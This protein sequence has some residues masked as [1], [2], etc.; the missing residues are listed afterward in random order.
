MAFLGGYFGGNDAGRQ[1]IDQAGQALMAATGAANKKY[2]LGEKNA[3]GQ[4]GTNYYDPYTQSGNQANDMYAN[5]LGLR[6]PGGNQA[7]V[8]AYQTN[9]GYGFQMQQG[10]QALDRS[11]AGSGMFGSGNAAMALNQF[12]QGVANQ[13][14]GNWLSRLQGLGAQG[15]Q[16]A[17]GQ[18]GRQGSLAGINMW[19]AG[20]QANNI[21][22]AAKQYANMIPNGMQ[23]DATANR[24]GGENIL[25]AIL[26]GLNLGGK[27]VPMLSDR[28]MKTDIQPLGRDPDTGLPIY[29]Y[30]YKGDAKNTQKV[31]GP[32]AQDIEKVRPDL[33]H[34]IGGKR[35]I[36]GNWLAEMS[37]AA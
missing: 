10:Q 16:A 19:G 29:A 24:Q 8:G 35:M 21:M 31:V 1:G 13:D 3:L 27:A 32:M 28:T 23:A 12:G 33:V 30:R 11:A 36:A 17:G 34:T 4:Y 9:P 5:A 14:Y 7:A 37:K 15:L 2:Q 6:G 20:G 22:D 18:T 25:S 26:G